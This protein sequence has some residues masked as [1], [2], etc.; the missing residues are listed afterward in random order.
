MG[1]GVLPPRSE[2]LKHKHPAISIT[3]S[4]EAPVFQRGAFFPLWLRLITRISAAS[5]DPKLAAGQDPASGELLAARA[6]QLMAARYRWGIAEAWLH[7]L[8]EARRIREPFEIS[9]PLVRHHVL[10]A[11]DQIRS[12][13]QVLVSPLPTVRGV[14]MSIEI[15]RDGAGP[16]FNRSC[17]TPLTDVVE[18][19]IA[20]LDPLA[21]D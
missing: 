20:S 6:Q 11:E 16:I 18:R 7:L 10:D 15:L 9:V 3:S 17:H 4:D 5:L 14:A 2:P 8:I 21:F 1:W 12:L 13:A 19:I